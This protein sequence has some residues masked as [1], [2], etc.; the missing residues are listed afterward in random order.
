[1]IPAVSLSAVFAAIE[2]IANSIAELPF[3]VKT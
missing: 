2:I 3:N 1:M